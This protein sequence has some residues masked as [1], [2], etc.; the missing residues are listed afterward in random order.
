MPTVRFLILCVLFAP[1][2]QAA[3]EVMSDDGREILLKTDGSWE[4]KSN[5]RF[6]T[7]KDGRRVRL[8]ADGSWQYTGEQ[9]NPVQIVQSDK[10][11]KT[12]TG[13]SVEISQLRIETQRQKKSPSKKNS[14]KTTHSVFS[15]AVTLADASVPAIVPNLSKETVTVVDNDG[16]KYSVLSVSASTTS[17]KSG[18]SMEVVVRAD[19]SP[20]W[21]TTKTMSVVFEKAAFLSADSLSARYF[22]A[23]AKRVDVEELGVSPGKR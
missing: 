16:R 12:E 7:A 3:E 8:K 11:A 13:L 10:A 18:Q 2:L 22:M 21:W 1:C 23:D 14:S 5:D 17:L 15:V 20:H 4:F 6:A 19:G 9:I